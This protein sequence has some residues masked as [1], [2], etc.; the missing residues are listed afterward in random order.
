MHKIEA[1][2]RPAALEQVQQALNGLGIQGL[3]VLEVRGFG[4]QRGHREVY[5]GAEY[6]VDFVPKIKVE[7]VVKTSD[8]DAAIDAI[9]SAAKTG[10]VG[11]G[12]VFSSPIEQAIRVRTGETGEGAL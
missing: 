8:R 10:S 12:K 2:L 6:T 9:V 4:R 1:F 5:R 11:D 3:S 7:V